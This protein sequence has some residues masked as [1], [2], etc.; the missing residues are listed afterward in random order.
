MFPTL[1]T[2]NFEAPEDPAAIEGG[3]IEGDPL[4]YETEQEWSGP[5]QEEW[6]QVLE[7]TAMLREALA[8]GGQQ[9]Q[10]VEPGDIPDPYDDPAG[11]RDFLLSQVEE[12]VSPIQNFQE[13]LQME[14]G[15]EV[16]LDKLDELQ[17]SQ[18][19]FLHPE[20]SRAEAYARAE[21]HFPEMVARFGDTAKAGDAALARGYKEQRE[22]ELAIGKA[23]YEREM[24]QLATLSGAPRDLSAAGAQGAQNSEIPRGDE[25][26][27]VAKHFAN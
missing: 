12:R 6:Q 24:N 25:M 16:G 10:G 7:T 4:D 5:A 17:Q 18:G 15:R 26:S 9:A 22:Y 21:R 27:V 14:E 3:G 1:H 20:Q 23:Y 2:L 19:E 8:S 11:Y 13:R